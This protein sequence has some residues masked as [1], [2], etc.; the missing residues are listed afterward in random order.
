M[1]N[2][3]IGK[4]SP[5]ALH[6]DAGQTVN[7]VEASWK[8]PRWTAPSW[9]AQYDPRLCAISTPSSSVTSYPAQ[10]KYVSRSAVGV[11]VVAAVVGVVDTQDGVDAGLLEALL[12][13]LG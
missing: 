12:V 13:A 1:G 7:T 10:P 5:A 4:R 3:W 6:V 11:A 8:K 2:L 9:L